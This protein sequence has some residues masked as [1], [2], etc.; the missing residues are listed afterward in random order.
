MVLLPQRACQRA[1]QV[2]TTCMRMMRKYHSSQHMLTETTT[3]RRMQKESL[4]AVKQLSLLLVF[5][6]VPVTTSITVTRCNRQLKQH[7]RQHQHQGH[8]HASMRA[9][10][11]H[12][13]NEAEPVVVPTAAATAR[14]CNMSVAELLIQL[15]S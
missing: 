3:R 12:Q 15:N 4:L 6:C 7:S 5:V 10:T 11:P 13:P 14:D 1:H 2:R 9:L 8:T